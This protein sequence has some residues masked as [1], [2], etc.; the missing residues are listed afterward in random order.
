MTRLGMLSVPASAVIK[1]KGLLT[2]SLGIEINHF[3]TI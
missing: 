1:R 3:M 2:I